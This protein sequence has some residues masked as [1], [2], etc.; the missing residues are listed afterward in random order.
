MSARV[1]GRLLKAY[2]HEARQEE[3]MRME[4]TRV[5]AS[6]REQLTASIMCGRLVEDGLDAWLEDAEIVA[7]APAY[8][9]AYGGVKLRVP[10]SQVERARA[11]LA[12][13]AEG[14]GE[15]WDDG[16]VEDEG[17]L[18][19]AETAVAVSSADELTCPRCGSHAIRLG[20]T[21]KAT[22]G[23]TG[24]VGALPWVV[25]PGTSW[26]VLVA[27]YGLRLFWFLAFVSVALYFMRAFD[28]RCARCG[29][30]DERAAF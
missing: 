19:A 30:T 7:T 24:V 1:D 17:A 8:S 5:I 26:G 25:P 28:M 15:E 3:H 9:L 27:A 20:L 21:G 29:H 12:E 16:F 6:Y 13:I 22:F 4:P 2:A 18:V 14:P 11:I 10:E 23:V